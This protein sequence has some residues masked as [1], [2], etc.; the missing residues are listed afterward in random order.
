M[1]LSALSVAFAGPWLFDMRQAQAWEDKFLRLESAAPAVSWLYTT[2]S[3]DKLTRHLESYLNIQLKTGETAL[4]RFYDPRVLN[5]I[6][7]LF[8]PEQLTHFT[9]DIE[10]WQ[11]QLNNTAYIVKG[12]AS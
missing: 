11:Y 10:E 4:L 9:Q 5:Q 6:P 2:Q 7:H 1:A 12:I 3:L 8:T